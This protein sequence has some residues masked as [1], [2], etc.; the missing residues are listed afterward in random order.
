[1]AEMMK[2]GQFVLT[3]NFDFLIEY[4]LQHS[5]IPKGEVKIVITNRMMMRNFSLIAELSLF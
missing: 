3:T 4:A 5:G 2:N 1:L